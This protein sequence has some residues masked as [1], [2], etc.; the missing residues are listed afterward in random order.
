MIL[1]QMKKSVC[2]RKQCEEL[3]QYRTLHGKS[4]RNPQE[5]YTEQKQMYVFTITGN[6]FLKDV[7][8]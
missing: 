3:S 2:F 6:K 1:F 5:K 7:K 4:A 8:L